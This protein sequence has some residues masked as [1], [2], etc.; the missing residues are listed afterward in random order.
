MNHGGRCIV[1]PEAE[2]IAE[3]SPTHTGPV[4]EGKTPDD[5]EAGG[6]AANRRAGREGMLLSKL[7]GCARGSFPFG[8]V[9]R[10]A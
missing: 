3:S 10:N 2:E 6:G 1:R 5:D 7:I 4:D 8:R 9:M